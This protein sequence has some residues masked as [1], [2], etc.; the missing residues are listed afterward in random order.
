MADA[1]EKRL[2]RLESQLAKLNANFDSLRGELD[3]TMHGFNKEVTELY[4]LDADFTK[5]FKILDKLGKTVSSMDSEL[6][7]LHEEIDE[8]RKS[9]SKEVMPLFDAETENKKKFRSVAAINRNMS[10]KI[11]ATR[12]EIANVAAKQAAMI[13]SWNINVLKRTDKTLADVNKVIEAI[14]KRD[15]KNVRNLDKV[16]SG[17]FAISKH[18]A[19]IEAEHIDAKMTARELV[20]K[21]E[22]L[23]DTMNYFFKQSESLNNRINSNT[24][25]ATE[26][27]AALELI[28][29]KILALESQSA[30]LTEIKDML[31]QNSRNIDQLTQKIAY[32]EKATVKTIVL[33]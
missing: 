7:T 18:A 9:F 8:E 5:K 25:A 15:S 4:D 22:N 29:D 28:K 6:A 23:K 21:A 2:K 16:H 11:D 31:E 20:I 10:A 12:T 3:S 33:E 1:I 19:D 13:K 26:I 14:E 32:L 17:I 24:A 30:Q 27:T